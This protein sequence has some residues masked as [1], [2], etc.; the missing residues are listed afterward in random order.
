[1]RKYLLAFLLCGIFFLYPFQIYIIG[2]DLGIGI[3][4]AVYRFQITT[5]G[6]TFIPITSDL[7]FIVRGI[8]TA[9]TGLSVIIWALGTI[10]LTATTIFALIN[11]DSERT[12]FRRQI[13]YGLA[14]VCIF[15]LLSCI[16]QYGIFF[17]GQ[18]G[19]SFP[20][21]ILLLLIWITSI[22]VYYDLF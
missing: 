14:G 10:L 3:E 13:S 11:S 20:L 8:Y 19:K 17:S 15:Y 5:Y 2:T 12:D 18:A 16:I 7:M 6:N 9:K 21:G 4:G 1:M 22:N